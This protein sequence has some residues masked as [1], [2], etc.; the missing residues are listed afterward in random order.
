M[1]N[2]L[3][4]IIM[5]TTKQREIISEVLSHA[6]QALSADQLL[7]KCRSKL[8]NMGIATVHRALKRLRDDNQVEEIKLTNDVLRFCTKAKHHHHHFKCNSCNK[9]YDIDCKGVNVKLP[10]GF[11]K[12]EYELNVFGICGNC[13][14]A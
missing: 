6:D 12:A 10:K 4:S 13:A 2:G 11:I 1:I 14:R 9:V 8:P 7:A 5:K 3:S